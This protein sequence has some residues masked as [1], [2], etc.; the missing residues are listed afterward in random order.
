MV[1]YRDRDLQVIAL[2]FLL[3]APTDL[4]FG[5]ATLMLGFM[6]YF[7]TPFQLAITASLD[8]SGRCIVL[9]VSAIKSSYVASGAILSILL[10]GGASLNRV[11]FLSFLCTVISF[12]VYF[13]LSLRAPGLPEVLNR[14]TGD[15]EGKA[16]T[17]GSQMRTKAEVVWEWQR[18]RTRIERIELP[19][20]VPTLIDR[21]ADL[22]G[23][24]PAWVFFQQGE[25]LTFR[26]VRDLSLRAAGLLRS[27]GV[28]RGDHV[29]VM[30]ANSS[31]Y[32]GAWLGLARLGAAI[33]PVNTRYTSRELG[34]VLNTARPHLFIID[35]D[36]LTVV[37]PLQRDIE[38][39]S[40]G[41][42]MVVGEAANHASWNAELAAA[43]SDNGNDVAITADDI[44]NIQFTSGTTGFP[45]GCMLSQ[46]YW[47]NAAISWGEYLEIPISRVI[48]NQHLFYLDG[49]FLA[50]VC[51]YKGATY[52]VCSK[53]SAAL[54]S[55]WLADYRIDYCWYFDPLF[56]V[57]AAPTDANS[58]LR[59]IHIFGFSPKNHA[60]LEQ[61]YGSIAR[62]GFG[63]SEYAPSLMMPLDAE[64]MV[65]SGSCGL[66]APHTK[67]KI[68]DDGGHE[69]PPGTTGE[70]WV[71]S[72]AVMKGYVD[73]PAATSESFDGDWFKTG[74][75]FQQDEDGFFFIV[76][77]KKDMV[78]K[79]SENI[80]C[81]E[82][83]E[84]IR[85]I[86]E[87]L[88]VAMVAV[89]DDFVGEEPKVYV[90]LRNGFSAEQ[91]PPARI[92]DF[93][94]RELAPFKV[95]RY[96]EYVAAFPMTESARVA[97]KALI[98]SVTDLRVNSYDRIDSVWR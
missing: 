66:Q 35:S 80:A 89:K 68:V 93:C 70:L 87:V 54:F 36:L 83:E 23:D 21:A 58:S 32:L 51:L 5:L 85:R 78:R 12:G 30:V 34:H 19:A 67:A 38:F 24:R 15:A 17:P 59:L 43:A 82:V 37:E 74:D 64:V 9:F 79:N 73:D 13:L 1:F 97:K 72:H 77:R 4:G 69:V 88:E 25:T 20:N 56:K 50:M 46:R 28:R 7:S 71:R 96:I 84:I 98:A 8:P 61:R 18:T 42:V 62:E 60:A 75:L 92:I 65:G 90:Q 29:A 14:R 49:Q 52:Y 11:I 81:R 44:M 86:P 47:V 26:E 27:R 31:V 48:C 91:V 10:A 55:Q 45:K 53:P 22:F 63:M 76:G 95:P 57:P 41:R 2:G 40:E 39:L 16:S 6:W 3:L 33:V 94:M